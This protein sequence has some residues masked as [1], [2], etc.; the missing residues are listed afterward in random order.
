MC[1]NNYA[2]INN[3]YGR[4]LDLIFL[5]KIHMRTRK[6]FYETG[7]ARAVSKVRLPC[8]APVC[9][10]GRRRPLSSRKDE[11]VCLK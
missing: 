1:I 10:I 6:N 5:L 8:P 7:S 3:N 4:L 2:A 11:I 9:L